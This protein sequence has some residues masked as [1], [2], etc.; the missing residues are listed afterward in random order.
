[1]FL[2]KECLCLYGHRQ[3]TQAE[4][5]TGWG[6]VGRPCTILHAQ[7]T[8]RGPQHEPQHESQLRRA[9]HAIAL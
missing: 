2:Y 3:C 9:A 8:Q 6:T 4:R 5:G 7:H 1:M